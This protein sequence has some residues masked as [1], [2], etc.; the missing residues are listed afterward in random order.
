VAFRTLHRDVLDAAALDGARGLRRM[1]WLGVRQRPAALGIA[2]LV[3]CA[4]A[5][6]ELSATVMVSPPGMTTVS[7]RVF[8]LLHAGVREQVA[9]ICLTN[10][11]G[12]AVLAWVIALLGA[13]WSRVGAGPAGTLC[14]RDD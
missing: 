5:C 14:A 2:W 9:A 13:R 3:A 8:R 6:G 4:T 11:L 7:I 10:V 12:V 1:W